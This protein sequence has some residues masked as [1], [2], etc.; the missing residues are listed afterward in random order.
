MGLLARLKLSTTRLKFADQ[1]KSLQQFFLFICCHPVTGGTNRIRGL[2]CQTQL[3]LEL[4]LI[5]NFL[6]LQ[7]TPWT[8]IQQHLLALNNDTSLAGSMQ[9]S[10][11]VYFEK[12]S[13]ETLKLSVLLKM[14]VG[15]FFKVFMLSRSILIQINIKLQSPEQNI[16]TFPIC[17]FPFDRFQS[18][19]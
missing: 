3:Q 15:T 16:G 9:S 5:F 2:Y 11:N 7:K 19:N 14:G 12:I 17:A 6:Q 10:E 4:E 1:A 13:K 18:Y 8:F